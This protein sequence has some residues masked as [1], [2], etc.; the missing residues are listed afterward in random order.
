MIKK[1]VFSSIEAPL[2]AITVSWLSLYKLC[3]PVFGQFVPFF[4]ADPVKL[5]QIR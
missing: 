4:P 1:A 2:G 3:K 5:Y